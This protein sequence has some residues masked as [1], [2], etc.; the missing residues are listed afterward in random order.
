[1]YEV[2]EANRMN[3]AGASPEG[4]LR[5]GDGALLSQIV[6]HRGAGHFEP[7]APERI[8]FIITFLARPRHDKDSRQLARGTYFHQKWSQWGHTWKDLQDP[9]RSMQRPFSVLRALSIWKPSNYNWGYDMVTSIMMQLSNQMLHGDDLEKIVSVRMDSVGFPKWLR[10]P[11][12][13]QELSQREAW[14]IFWDE[15]VKRT[16]FFVTATAL[17]THGVYLIIAVAL[18][19]VASR[20]GRNGWSTFNKSISRLKMTHGLI[21]LVVV[22]LYS[23]LRSSDWSKRVM[24]GNELMQPFPSAHVTIDEELVMLPKGLTTFPAAEDVL[25]GSRFDAK[26]M[27]TFE[28]YLDW[29]KGN[30]VYRGEI[31]SRAALYGSYASLPATFRNRLV[32]DTL[33]EIDEIRGR[34]LQQDYRTGNWHIM[35]EEAVAAKVQ[36]DLLFSSIPVKHAVGRIIDR[37]IA[38]NRFG[39]LRETVMGVKASVYLHTVKNM[40]TEKRDAKTTLPLPTKKRFF[41]AERIQTPRVSRHDFVPSFIRFSPPSESALDPFRVGTK[42]WAGLQQRDMAVEYYRGAVVGVSDDGPTS[43]VVSFEDNEKFEGLPADALTVYVPVT[44]GDRVVGCFVE[45]FEDCYPGTVALVMPDASISILYDDG[46]FDKKRPRNFYY[47]DPFIYFAA[48]S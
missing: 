46:D 21:Y 1:M 37:E 7:E 26:W 36:E 29:H 11:V 4:Q 47:A 43:Y 45:G 32:E 31:S 12:K 22:L 8:M 23:R 13:E 14:K 41:I 9:M 16:T 5:A 15:T 2:C 33:R 39:K 3:L 27:G 40:L 17:L 30:I 10:G 38:D 6:W 20:R 25:I 19:G 28:R 48:E 34:F 24:K 42:V 44:E 18:A 35:P